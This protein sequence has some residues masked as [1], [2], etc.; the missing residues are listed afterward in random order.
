M[1][2]KE[3]DLKLW[4][5]VYE[6]ALLTNCGLN[7]QEL[8]IASFN[9]QWLLRAQW[10]SVQIAAWAVDMKNSGAISIL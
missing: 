1:L 8:G 3:A 4:G 9:P 7:F 5:A 6:S 10:E 2:F